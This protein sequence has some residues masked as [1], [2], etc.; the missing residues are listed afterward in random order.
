M[1]TLSVLLFTSIIS[2]HQITAKT[3]SQE[4]LRHEVFTILHKAFQA[5]LQLGNHH[6]TKEEA[7]K[8]LTPHFQ[9]PYIKKFLD[10]N[11]TQEAQ[12]YIT[13]GTDFAL[14]Y[15]P[16]FSYDEHTQITYADDGHT[17][18]VYEH[19]PAVEDGP[20]SYGEH[21]ECII[22]TKEQGIWKVSDYLYSEDLPKEME[23]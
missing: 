16:Y 10:E 14:Y 4:P 22:L 13:Y 20:V 2:V 7:Q 6:R 5:Q 21:Y 15:I 18:Y 11:M 23:S 19:F 3:V 8:L 12:G 17:V 1:A 9:K